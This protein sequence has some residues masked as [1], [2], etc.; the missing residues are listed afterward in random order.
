LGHSKIITGI[1]AADN[2]MRAIPRYNGI[3]QGRHSHAFLRISEAFE[4]L[5]YSGWGE[6]TLEGEFGGSGRILPRDFGEQVKMRWS[7][8]KCEGLTTESK[9]AFGAR[10][11]S[12]EN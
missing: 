11:Y 6:H 8:L 1:N 7:G 10:I 4:L 12:E 2:R 5:L 3:S 9:C